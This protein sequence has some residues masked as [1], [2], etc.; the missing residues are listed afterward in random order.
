LINITLLLYAAAACMFIAGV[1]HLAIVPMFFAQMSI[2]VTIFFVVSGLAQLFWVIPTIK[3]WSKPW[4]YV[5]IGGTVILIIMYFVAVPGSGY[6]IS[7]LDLA[8]EASQIIF[9]ILCTIIIFKDRTTA[10]V[11]EKRI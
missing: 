10:K 4:F 6:P 2:D 11:S 1:L 5:G 8:I 7:P 3:K 9:V